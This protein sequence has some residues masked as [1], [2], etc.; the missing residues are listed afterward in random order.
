MHKWEIYNTKHIHG[1]DT[2]ALHSPVLLLMGAPV[3]VVP[4]YSLY[5]VAHLNMSEDY[6][7]YR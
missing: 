7:K 3:T 1:S 2:T 5:I 6:A 4:Q